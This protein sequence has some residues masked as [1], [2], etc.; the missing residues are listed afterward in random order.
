MRALI[1]KAA[2]QLLGVFK[3]EG[4]ALLDGAFPGK[5]QNPLSVEQT[6]GYFFGASARSA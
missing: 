4:G 1:L 6:A 5:P 2:L 3:S